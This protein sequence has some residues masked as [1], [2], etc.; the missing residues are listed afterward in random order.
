[1]P[2]VKTKMS[3]SI[4]VDLSKGVE[5]LIGSVPGIPDSGYLSV[6]FWMA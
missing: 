6:L 4:K 1:M 5:T 2:Q 3:S